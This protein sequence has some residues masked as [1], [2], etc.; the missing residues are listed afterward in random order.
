M[1]NYQI[2]GAGDL[3]LIR[4]VLAFPDNFLIWQINIC[5]MGCISLQ[6]LVLFFPLLPR[7]FRV[8]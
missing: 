6:E 1:V 7:L 8:L 2:I 5:K 3:K 4:S